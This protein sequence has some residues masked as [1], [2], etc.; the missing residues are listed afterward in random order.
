MSRLNFDDTFIIYDYSSWDEQQKSVYKLLQHYLD[1]RIES[2]RLW[3]P[4]YCQFWRYIDDMDIIGLERLKDYEIGDPNGSYRWIRLAIQMGAKEVNL[5]YLD[6]YGSAFSYEILSW[7]LLPLPSKLKHLRLQNC[8]ILASQAKVSDHLHLHSLATLELDDV[9]V[10]KTKL[11]SIFSTCVNL[12]KLV[13]RECF[14]KRDLTI[15]G[16]PSLSYNEYNPAERQ[17]VYPKPKISFSNVPKLEEIRLDLDLHR[18]NRTVDEMFI[19]GFA[20]DAPQLKRLS[21]TK[22]EFKFIHSLATLKL[23]DLLVDET[24]LESIFS[25][26]VNL[27]KLVLRKCIFNHNLTI[28]DCPSLSNLQIFSPMHLEKLQVISLPNLTYFEFHIIDDDQGREREGVYPNPKLCFSNV[29]KLEEMRLDLDLQYYDQ[30]VDGMFISGFATD[31]PQL[32][33]LASIHT[34][35]PTLLDT[36]SEPQIPVSMAILCQL[37]QLELIL[38]ITYCNL[39]NM[40]PHVLLACPLLQKFHLTAYDRP[41][42]IPF[43]TCSSKHPFPNLKQVKIRPF[44]GRCGN[45]SV[46][47]LLENAVALERII[48]D[49]TSC[50]CPESCKLKHMSHQV[51]NY[52]QIRAKVIASPI[53]NLVLQHHSNEGIDFAKIFLR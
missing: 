27:W 20:A 46:F 23:E 51:P 52:H 44:Y 40:I 18:Y 49:A 34:S 36:N 50:P 6:D 9:I 16:C 8:S 17:M 4:D 22:L 26:C 48:L 15:T 28:A 7:L 24:V 12:W 14:F 3:V 29:P 37:E 31:A 21:L 5:T 25:T 10:D 45:P 11:G 43:V 47:Y 1:S 41:S 38:D 19:T 13:L 35:M 42:K 39:L 30:T 53:A 32:K 33:R 2:F